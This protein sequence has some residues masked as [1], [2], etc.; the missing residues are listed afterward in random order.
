MPCAI[1]LNLPDAINIDKLDLVKTKID[2]AEGIVNQM[3][4]PDIM[5][6]ATF[7]K[8][9]AH[10]ARDSATRESSTTATIRR[11]RAIHPAIDGRAVRF[12]M[13]TW[14]RFI[15]WIL[16]TRKQIQ[17]FI[18]RSWFEYSKGDNAG[19]HPWDGE[20]SPKY[21]GPKPPYEFLEFEN[22]YSWMKAPRWRGHAMEGGPLTRCLL[23]Y[24]QKD[25]EMTE[26]INSTL[27]ALD[28]PVGALYSTLGRT[29]ARALETKRS[30][31]LLRSLYEEL[32]ANIKGGDSNTVNNT[33][34]DPSTW[35]ADELK[36]VGT[37]AAPRGALAHWVRIKDRKIENYQ[38]VVA[39]TWNGSPMDAN[40][41]HGPMEAALIGTPVHDP[42]KPLE[43]FRTIHSYDPCLACSTHVVDMDGNELTRVKVQ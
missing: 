20:T 18:S 7:Y 30:L 13:E 29:A 32:I 11:S 9:W 41:Q 23:A 40:G 22:K 39:T 14:L 28:V 17:E 12:W 8:D 27:K 38:A 1:N 24:A 16:R 33:K 3:L 34:F 6:I 36:G 4:L 43:I 26:Y 42:E 15:R 5:A 31:V 37:Y 21:N 25:A 2:E 19:M 35:P 10:G